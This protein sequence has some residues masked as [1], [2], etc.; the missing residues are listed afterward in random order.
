MYVRFSVS[1]TT[2]ISGRFK[3]VISH[4]LKKE[5][6]HCYFNVELD[7]FLEKSSM[8]INLFITVG[9]SKLALYRSEDCVQKVAVVWT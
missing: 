5:E 6:L 9:I 2:S 3:R 4:S 7:C 1:D 8:I